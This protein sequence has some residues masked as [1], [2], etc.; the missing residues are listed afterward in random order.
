ME[1]KKLLYLCS[2]FCTKHTTE[3]YGVNYKIKEFKIEVWSLLPLINPNLY[4]NFYNK[5]NKNELRNKNFIYI[6]SIKQ[7][8]KLLKK[9]K[10]NNF[11]LNDIPPGLI[12]VLIDIYLSKIKKFSKINIIE[13]YPIRPKINIIKNLKNNLK[14]HFLYIVKKISLFLINFLYS[15]I[16]NFFLSRPKFIF[17][18]NTTDYNFY[19][20]KN[21]LN[22]NKFD[23]G[24]YKKYLE[25]RKKSTPKKKQIVF[26]DQDFDHNFEF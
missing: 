2:T 20:K 5:K 1:V 19:K 22:L 6:K 21:F 15:K 16:I 13:N 11:F 10:K 3:L 8:F 12:L 24:D 23:N 7:L 25:S 14:K 4:K 17:V 18:D 9:Q 26:L